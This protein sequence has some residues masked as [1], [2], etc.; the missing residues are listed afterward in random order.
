MGDAAVDTMYANAPADQRHIQ[1]L[2]SANCFGDHY[3]RTGL[4]VPTRELL[5]LAMPAAPF[6]GYP[7]T[8]NALSALDAVAPAP[9][10]PSRK[11]DS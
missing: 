1:E 3:T 9:D 2:L 7:R 11:E 5:T 10:A 6:I 4:D 8:L